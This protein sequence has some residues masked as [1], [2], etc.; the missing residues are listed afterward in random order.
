LEEALDHLEILV[1]ERPLDRLCREQPTTIRP[2]NPFSGDLSSDISEEELE[3][4]PEEIPEHIFQPSSE[5][6]ESNTST[7]RYTDRSSTIDSSHSS[8]SAE[9]FAASRVVSDLLSN[10]DKVASTTFDHLISSLTTSLTGTSAAVDPTDTNGDYDP[11]KN[12]FSPF[13][14]R[15]S[16]SRGHA[17]GQVMPFECFNSSGDKPVIPL[18]HF[19]DESDTFTPILKFMPK[20]S[21]TLTSFGGHNPFQVEAW[22]KREVQTARPADVYN[23]EVTP[24]ETAVTDDEDFCVHGNTKRISQSV[25]ATSRKY[26]PCAVAYPTTSEF[27]SLIH[28]DLYGFGQGK[29]FDDGCCVVSYLF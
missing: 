5:S 7:V 2:V 26:A 1:F 12:P 11:Q 18:L 28:A 13:Y 23:T 20:P 3:E 21:D 4:I 8:K 19:T 6:S 16:T 25:P 27:V 24:M 29:H 17:K 15:S 9:E 10:P 22:A 14:R